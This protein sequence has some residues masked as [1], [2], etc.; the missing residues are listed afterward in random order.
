MFMLLEQ[1]VN[2]LEMMHPTIIFAW[3][4]THLHGYHIQRCALHRVR[5]RTLAVGVVGGFRFSLYIHANW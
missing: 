5:L 3:L 4:L 1:D 2:T